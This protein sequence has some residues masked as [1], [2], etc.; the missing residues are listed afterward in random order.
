M[1]DTY[2]ETLAALSEEAAQ[3]VAADRLKYVQELYREASKRMKT[4]IDAL[5]AQIIDSGAESVTRTQLWQYSKYKAICSR[6][7][8]TPQRSKPHSKRRSSKRSGRCSRIRS[9]PRWTR[10]QELA[11]GHIKRT[12]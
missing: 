9:A 3:R 10:F 11:A 8:S 2:W 5:F 7:T 4:E 1:A 12:R 6:L